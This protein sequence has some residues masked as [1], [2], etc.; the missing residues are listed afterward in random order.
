MPIACRSGCS[1]CCHLKVETRPP[2]VFSLAAWLQKHF[3]DKQRAALL[4][5][6]HAH[7]ARLE[8][9]ASRSNRH[10]LSLPAAPEWP[11]QCVRRAA[12]SCRIAHSMDVEPCK[13]AFDHPEDLD[14]PSGADMEVRLGLRVGNDGVAWAFRESG[15]DDEL[16]HLSAALAEALTDPEAEARWRGKGRAFSDAALARS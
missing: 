2:D 11:M 15:F 13:Y 4:Q 1:G 6:L 9:S 14:A 8:G 10:Q 7:V 5:R 3:T 16:Y 12:S